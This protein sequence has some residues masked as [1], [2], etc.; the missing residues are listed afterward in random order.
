MRIR[1]L[2]TLFQCINFSLNLVI[3]TII[4]E[5]MKKNTS[6]NTEIKRYPSGDKTIKKFYPLFL[7]IYHILSI[8]SQTNF[9]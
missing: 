7:K 9:V 3:K 2:F 1:I 8:K 6:Q 5:F 4:F